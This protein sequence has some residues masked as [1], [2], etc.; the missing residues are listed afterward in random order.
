MLVGAAEGMLVGRVAGAEVVGSGESRVGAVVPA[1]TAVGR[2]EVGAPVKTGRETG[3][4]SSVK[5][6]NPVVSGTAVCA[7]VDG[8]RVCT[9]PSGVHEAACMWPA[10]SNMQPVAWTGKRAAC[11]GQHAT[12]NLQKDKMQ[13]IMCNRQHAANTMQQTTC[14][15]QHAADTVLRTARHLFAKLA[16]CSTPH[17]RCGGSAA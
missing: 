11:S 1:A 14:I 13:H 8:A 3:V 7:G 16:A 10:P 2:R 12:D 6:T 15:G 5:L 4:G 9:Q 17:P